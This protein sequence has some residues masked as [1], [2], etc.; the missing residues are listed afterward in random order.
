METK[1]WAIGTMFFLTLLTSTAQILWK[2]GSETLSFD[3]M[4]II[5]NYHLLIGIILY[6]IAGAL[7]ILSFRGGDVSVLYPIVATSY[8]WVSILSIYFLSEM[9]NIFKWL[10]VLIIFLGIAL[11]GFGSKTSEVMKRAGII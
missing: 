11:I 3:I 10:G 5:T 1:L 2:I 7:M 9:M 6:V 8:I 4:T